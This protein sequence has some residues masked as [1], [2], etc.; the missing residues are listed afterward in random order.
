MSDKC[1]GEAFLTHGLECVRYGVPRG[2]YRLV[3]L[4]FWDY[5]AT[6]VGDYE[7]AEKAKS[8]ICG[9]LGEYQDYVIYDDA[10]NVVYDHGNVTLYALL[11]RDM[12]F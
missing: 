3:L 7:T 10:G 2:R 5:T 12:V 4:D 6:V 8:Q 11:K 9:D 1:T